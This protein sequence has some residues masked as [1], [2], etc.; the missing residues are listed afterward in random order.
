MRHSNVTSFADDTRVGRRI[1]THEDIVLL[2]EDL[3]EIYL[4]TEAN[5]MMFNAEKF[6][7]VRY[8][9]FE[10]PE[11]F[12]QAPDGTEIVRSS[13][14]KD[15]GVHMNENLKFTDHIQ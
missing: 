8:G 15:L 7:H 14:I 6:I 12:Y 4:W 3:K 1:K 9:G 10:A 11:P 5:N 13:Q 2:S